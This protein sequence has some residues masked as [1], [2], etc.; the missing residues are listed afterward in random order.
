MGFV[1][2]LVAAAIALAV[3]GV[4]VEGLF[5]LLIIGLVV[6]AAALIY[7]TMRSWRRGGPRRPRR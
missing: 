2:A 5:Y 4:I 7:A 1:L 3:I 6:L